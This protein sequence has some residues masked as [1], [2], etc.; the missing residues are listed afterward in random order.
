VHAEHDQARTSLFGMAHNGLRAAGDNVGAVPPAQ[1]ESAPTRLL[2]QLCSYLLGKRRQQ[3]PWQILIKYVENGNPR[4][5]LGGEL[6]GPHECPGG[7]RGK[8]GRNNDQTGHGS[9]PGAKNAASTLL[10]DRFEQGLRLRK[11]SRPVWAT[12][13]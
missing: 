8:I 2:Q 12:P 13:L 6:L 4:F 11:H 3:P 10:A 1:V 5:V 7:S 9:T